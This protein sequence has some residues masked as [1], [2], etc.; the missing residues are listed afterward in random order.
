MY[1]PTFELYLGIP[2]Q[3]CQY[4]LGTNRFSS[5]SISGQLSISHSFTSC[6]TDGY[7]APFSFAT[8]PFLRPSPS[9]KVVNAQTYAKEVKSLPLCYT[10]SKQRRKEEG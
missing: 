5:T 8:P 9:L 3:D 2:K 4:V 7:L 6:A 1:K 10:C